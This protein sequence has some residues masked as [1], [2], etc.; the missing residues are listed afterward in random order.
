MKKTLFIFTFLIVV[1]CGNNKTEYVFD[2]EK[3]DNTNKIIQTLISNKNLNVFNS[4]IPVCKELI[5]NAIYEPIPINGI[6][7]FPPKKYKFIRINELL[8]KEVDGKV[9]FNPKDSTFIAN[10]NLNPKKIN[11]DIKILPKVKITTL[12]EQKLKIKNSEQINFYL[13]NIPI[14]SS[15]NNKAYIEVDKICSG[16]CGYGTEI[17]LEKLNGKWKI[18]KS[19]L[20]WI[21]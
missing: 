8:Q 12:K 21:N 10:Q 13:I 9:F 16:E 17:Y 3:T 2:S 18:I 7:K 19:K 1:S 4:S 5:G 20:S 15:D 14:F 6:I 11:I